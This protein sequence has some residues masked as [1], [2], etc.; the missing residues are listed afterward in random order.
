MA[1]MIDN[2]LTI[3][4]MRFQNVYSETLFSPHHKPNTLVCVVHNNVFR[5]RLCFR[6][7]SRLNQPAVP[8]IRRTQNTLDATAC[9]IPLFLSTQ[10]VLLSLMLPHIPHK[11]KKHMEN[12]MTHI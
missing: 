8:C 12:Q 9:L 1:G 2:R 4:Y 11:S 5:S 6:Y 3:Y 10:L 7:K